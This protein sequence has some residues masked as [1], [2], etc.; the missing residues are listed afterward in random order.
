LIWV[1][2]GGLLAVLVVASGVRLHRQYW[3]MRIRRFRRQ[4]A[5]KEIKATKRGPYG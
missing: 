5:I 3:D 2:I 1:L 4:Q